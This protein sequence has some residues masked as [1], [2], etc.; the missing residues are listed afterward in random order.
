MKKIYLWAS[1]NRHFTLM[2]TPSLFSSPGRSPGRAIVLPP[3]S[4]LAFASA[5]PLMLALALA[6]ASALAK[7][8]SFYVK[9]FYVMGKALLGELSCPCD[10]S[11][12]ITAVNRIK[13]NKYYA[14]VS[15]SFQSGL[16]ISSK[17]GYDHVWR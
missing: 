5:L 7:C 1:S 14:E 2:K 17:N 13:I 9:V 15:I 16:F 6:A 12:Y 3:A 10:R 4:A 11:C 8:L